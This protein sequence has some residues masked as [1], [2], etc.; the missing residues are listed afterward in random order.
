MGANVYV[1]FRNNEP[2]D[3]WVGRFTEVATRVPDSL[4]WRQVPPPIGAAWA[5]RWVCNG[6]DPGWEIRQVR[7]GLD[8]DLP[9]T[10][11]PR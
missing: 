3:S 10:S 4:G 9:L 11:G 6:G 7:L 2:V 5:A 1:I 8:I